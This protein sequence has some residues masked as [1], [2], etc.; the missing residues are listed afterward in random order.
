MIIRCAIQLCTQQTQLVRLPHRSKLAGV[1]PIRFPIPTHRSIKVPPRVTQGTV[2][3]NVTA[4]SLTSATTTPYA[5]EALET[6]SST[7]L[8]ARITP[9][10]IH[11]PGPKEFHVAIRYKVV[12]TLTQHWA[13]AVNGQ[14]VVMRE[15]H[16]VNCKV[17]VV[18][19]V[20]APAH[21]LASS[22]RIS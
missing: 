16:L 11:L 2:I 12:L 5:M 8:R 1:A 20:S 9:I 18:L 14:C 15:K 7:L 13:P 19:G 17:L 3:G 4:F 10:A 21:I 6:R 22:V